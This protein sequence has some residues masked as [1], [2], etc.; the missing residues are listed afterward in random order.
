MRKC[1]INMSKNK[2]E[3]KERKKITSLTDGQ[4]VD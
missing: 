3:R 1:Q 2:E 4:Q